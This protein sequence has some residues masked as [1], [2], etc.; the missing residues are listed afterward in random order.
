VLVLTEFRGRGKT[1]GVS[2]DAMQGGTILSFRDGKI[3][4]IAAY[5]GRAEAL[6]AWGLRE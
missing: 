5:T 2:V 3:V 4:R 1:S 6:E